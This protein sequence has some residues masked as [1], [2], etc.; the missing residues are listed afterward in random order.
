MYDKTTCFL[1]GATSET[2]TCDYC[3]HPVCQACARDWRAW[4]SNAVRHTTATCRPC[5]DTALQRAVRDGQKM[6]GNVEM[7]PSFEELGCWN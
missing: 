6:A 2:R 3:K 4:G 5:F 1:C 7:A